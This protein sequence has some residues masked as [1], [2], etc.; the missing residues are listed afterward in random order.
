M[1]LLTDIAR[2]I[3]N[4]PYWSWYN[5]EAKRL[6]KFH[7]L[8]Q[9]EDCFIIGNGPSLNKMDLSSLANYHTFGLNKIYLM[10]DRGIDLNLSYLVSVNQL[11]IEQSKD[12]Y[13][14]MDCPI[15]VSYKCKQ[16]EFETA[17]NIHYTLSWGKRVFQGDITQLINEGGTVTF[18]AMQIAF[19]MGFKRVFLIGVDHSFKQKGKANETQLM[20][21]DDANHFDPN[22]FKGQKWQLADLDR[23][24]QSYLMAGIAFEE[25]G[26]QI[27]DATV[28][29]KLDIFPKMDFQKALS[30]IKPKR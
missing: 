19:F 7:N 13:P 30:I 15:F 21:E 3:K 9:G 24:E 8:H 22:Y 14:T 29:G 28:G 5:K 18:V 27:I 20:E 6:E 2:R 25:D 1:E 11:V 16:P 12:K 26:R 23:S 10:E 17:S 4:I